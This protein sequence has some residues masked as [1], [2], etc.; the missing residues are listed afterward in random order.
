MFFLF[1]N[2]EIL[3][4]NY[5]LMSLVKTLK[6]C[7]YS[8]NNFKKFSLY[9]SVNKVTPPPILLGWVFEIIV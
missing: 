8:K 4:I 5:R 3:F 7:Y 1:S 2:L 6:R 9:L